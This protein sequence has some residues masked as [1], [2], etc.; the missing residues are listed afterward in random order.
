MASRGQQVALFYAGAMAP[1]CSGVDSLGFKTPIEAM[2]A[3]LGKDVQI[4]FA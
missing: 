2:H 4:M 1:F 3:G